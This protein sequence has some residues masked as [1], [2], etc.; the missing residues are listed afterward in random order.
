MLLAFTDEGAGPAVVLL[1]GFPLD[2]TMWADQVPALVPE[3]RVVVPDLR[4][5]GESPAPDS[6]YAME[7]MA[8]DVVE[9]LDGLALTEPVVFAGLSMGGYVAL[10]LAAHHPE[11]VRALILADTRAANDA[12]EAA[13]NREVN[14]RSVLAAGHPK[15][16][17]ESMIPKLFAPSS[18]RD[19]PELVARLRGAMEATSAAGVAGAL[20]GMAMRPD[21]RPELGSIAAPTLVVVGEHDA[22]SPPDEARAIA[23]ALP[24]G[25]LVTIPGAGHLSPC[26]NPGAFNAAALD[27]LRGLD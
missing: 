3:H 24:N 19:R 25:R 15:A 10:A 13:A 7:Q 2:R 16:L 18:L 14:A 4:G 6:V 12:P 23:E 27:F 1:H 8:E 20:R 21:R 5:H 22:V 26:E 11:R 17:V 9:L